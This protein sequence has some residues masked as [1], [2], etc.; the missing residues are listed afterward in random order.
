[1]LITRAPPPRYVLS[2]CFPTTHRWA[3]TLG[4][5]LVSGAAHLAPPAG[6]GANLALFDSAGLATALIA[7]SGDVE[8][9]LSTYERDMFT[10]SAAAATEAHRVLLSA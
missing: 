4:V 6:E 3:R 1:M 2:M 10:R 8:A 9:A 5:T 7:Q